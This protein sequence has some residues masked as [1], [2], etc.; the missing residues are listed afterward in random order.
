VPSA[1]T[2]GPE[3]L[4]LRKAAR[5]Q[6]VFSS[7]T[8]LELPNFVAS[9]SPLLRARL[10]SCALPEGTGAD[11]ELAPAVHMTV[12]APFFKPPA[13][14]RQ[15]NAKCRSRIFASD[16]GRML[17]ANLADGLALRLRRVPCAEDRNFPPFYPNFGS[18]PSLHSVPRSAF[19]LCHGK[20]CFPLPGAIPCA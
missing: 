2:P 15:V 10:C 19:V 1:R 12:N 14:L 4:L 18:A 9:T 16:Y 6:F 11:H 13:H 5:I 17:S 8:S 7:F 20:P 3:E